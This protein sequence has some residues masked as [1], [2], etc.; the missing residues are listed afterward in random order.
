MV[1]GSHYNPAFLTNRRQKIV[2][3]MKHTVADG[4][5]WDL[6]SALCINMMAFHDAGDGICAAS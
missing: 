4:V 6:S 5:S 2:F 3:T 1:V